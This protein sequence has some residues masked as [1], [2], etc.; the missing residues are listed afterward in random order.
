MSPLAINLSAYHACKPCKLPGGCWYTP[1]DAKHCA[2]EEETMSSSFATHRGNLYLQRM[3][4]LRAFTGDPGAGG[5]CFFLSV[6]AALQVWRSQVCALPPKLE[7]LFHPDA[8]RPFVAQR[9]RAIV[10]TTIAQ[11]GAPRFL[12]YVTTRCADE[13][14]PGSIHGRFPPC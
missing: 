2:A 6:A 3:H 12:D 4:R 7:V 13:L 11:W 1:R 8:P 10:A 14:E 5:D 9:L